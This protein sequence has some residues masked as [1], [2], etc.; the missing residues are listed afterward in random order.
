MAFRGHTDRV[1]GV[2]WHPR[3]LKGQGSTELQLASG[4][5]DGNIHLYGRASCVL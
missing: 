1:S 2:A 5:A 3:A 4:G